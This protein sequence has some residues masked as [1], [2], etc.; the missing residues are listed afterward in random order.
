MEINFLTEQ[1]RSE[2]SSLHKSNHDRNVCDRIKAVLLFDKGWSASQIAEAL[3]ISDS[4]ARTHLKEY[5]SDNKLDKSHRGAG[6]HELE[7]KL[8]EERM[9]GE[10]PGFS[11]NHGMDHSHQAQKR[12]EAGHVSKKEPKEHNHENSGEN[13]QAH[14]KS[15]G[16]KEDHE[17]N[18]AHH[19][20]KQHHGHKEKI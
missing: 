11:L 2:L 19:G 15:L 10:G 12:H 20:A 1:Q 4:T 5:R 17:V 6:H 16:N 7:Q 14:K 18:K 13:Q 9:A 8:D 3:M